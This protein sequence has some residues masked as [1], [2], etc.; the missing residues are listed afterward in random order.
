MK[1]NIRKIFALGLSLVLLLGMMPLRAD[2]Y[3][4]TSTVIIEPQYQEAGVFSEGYA[5]VKRDGL[6]GYVDEA[7]NEVVAPQYD[8]AGDVND[9]HAVVAKWE[10]VT[11]AFNEETG[12]EEPFEAYVMHLIDMKGKNIQLNNA[13]ADSVTGN[14]VP[15]YYRTMEELWDMS[16]GGNFICS[17]GVV[18][19][20]NFPYTTDGTPIYPRGTEN[21]DSLNGGYDWFYQ[22]APC[23]DGVIP[24]V[25][26]YR[27]QEADRQCFFMDLQGNIIKTFPVSG[28]FTETPG[29]RSVFAPQD[30]LILASQEILVQDESGYRCDGYAWGVMDKA[31][32]WVKEPSFDSF[33]YGS[34]DGGTFVDGLMAVRDI[35]TQKYGVINT[36]GET[37]VPPEIYDN[38]II[39][40]HGYVPALKNDGYVYL[41]TEGNPYQIA[42]VN[43]GIARISLATCFSDFGVAA[44]YDPERNVGY[45]ISSD[46]MNG[47][48][49]KVHG[50]EDLAFEA[51]FPDYDGDGEIDYVEEIDEIITIERD[52]KWGFARLELGYANPFDDISD[53]TQFYYE[54]VLWAVDKGI[55]TGMTDTTFVPGNDCTRGQI[56]TFLWRAKGQPEPASYENPFTDVAETD[57]FYKAVL[58]AYHAGITTGMT[59]TTFAPGASCTR[60]QAVTF[61]WRQMGE[62]VPTTT[63][64]SFT[65][66]ADGQFYAEAVCW[67]LDEAITNGM[68]DTT[69]GTDVTCSRGHIVTFLYRTYTE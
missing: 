5:F 42:G 38:I 29:I 39:Y 31:G 47:I 61:L 65:D 3:T 55:T 51:Y 14:T 28:S 36:D 68:D 4:I 58:W 66:T 35:A 2:A 6:W 32:N 48:L 30:G 40:S 63:A 46:A 34:D 57:F 56:V 52:G 41:D 67:A 62:P 60:A 7:G 50:S 43:G 12:T 54:P 20:A 59:E 8:W 53:S 13:T 16:R 19:T 25:A 64:D 45:C 49:P 22:T 37:V 44:V 21:L 26:A 18:L 69:F 17:D 15:L 27:G 23:V 24:M 1:T 11:G 9:G 33:W 10:T